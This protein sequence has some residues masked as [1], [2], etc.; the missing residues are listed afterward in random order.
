MYFERSCYSEEVIYSRQS[1]RCFRSNHFKTLFQRQRGWRTRRIMRERRLLEEADHLRQCCCRRCNARDLT[2]LQL[3]SYVR[4]R[5]FLRP[6]LYGLGYLRHSPPP[7]SYPRRD[8]D[9]QV[10]S[11]RRDNSKGGWGGV[12]ASRQVV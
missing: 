8:E 2:Q 9:H 10:V 6:H 3:R 5:G 7:A 4:L 12:V 11:G 1:L